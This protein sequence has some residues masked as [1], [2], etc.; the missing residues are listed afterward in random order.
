MLTP[1]QFDEL[2]VPI[3]ELYAEFEQ[4]VIEDIARRLARFSISSAAWETQR[5]IES[6]ALYDDVIQRLAK[7][8][9]KSRAEV[10]KTLR[11]A[12]VKAIK[13][14]DG[15]YRAMDLKP[16]PLNLSP[17]M[18][19]VLIANIN[20]TNGL[21]HNL[22]MTTAN[23]AQRE[24]IRALDIAH[25]Q[26]TTGAMSY[27]DA[28]RDAVVNLARGGMDVVS[29]PSGHTDKLDVAVRRA[30]MT[31]VGQTTAQLQME[32][33]GEMGQDLVE[34][35]AHA[36]ARNTGV[37]A[38]NHE[39]WQGKIYSLSGK[40]PRYKSFIEMTGY[41]TG[42]GL[43]GWNCRHSFYPFFEDYSSANYD[44]AALREVNAAT[45]TY[46]GQTMPVYDALQ[47]QRHIER[48]IRAWRRQAAALRALGA[49]A[50]AAESRVAL[51]QA[52]MR[53]FIKQT[54]FTRQYAREE[55]H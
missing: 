4:S 20:K 2:S 45:V 55:A 39:S 33:A 5:L 6:G 54:K 23:A 35:S 28:I 11:A 16:L 47:Y 8:S 52:R 44:A 15:V 40:H 19:R 53:D 29:Y 12:G 36:G 27:D 31:S 51:W 25:L 26:V 42:A 21:I 10:K 49:D 48:K 34:V 13:Y 3:V 24:F 50:S 46:N 43:G 22:T 17:A 7:I 37:G 14:D 9:K 18:L 30:V 32:R 1:A 41:G 38:A